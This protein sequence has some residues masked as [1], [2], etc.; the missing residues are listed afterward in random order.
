[1]KSNIVI[2]II[3][4]TGILGTIFK[5]FF[6]EQ[7]YEVLVSGRN[8]KLTSEELVKGA[9]VV[10]F[11]VPIDVT[12]E[13]IKSVIPYLR[14]EQ[15]LMDFTS[16]KLFSVKEMLKSRASVIGLH[17]MFGKVESVCGKTVVV[18]PA[19][20]GDWQEWIVDLLKKGEMKVKVTTADEHDKIMSVLQGLVH[21]NYI[22]LSYTL[23]EESE[24]LG[25][26]IN[27][28]LDYGGVI[29]DLRLGTMARTLGQDPEL[30][31]DLSMYNEEIKKRIKENLRQVEKLKKIIDRKDKVEFIKYFKEGVK[32]YKDFE[33]EALRDSAFLIK[34]LS[35]RKLEDK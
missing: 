19:R 34:Q 5:K 7:G 9:K 25:L 10:I 1:M 16:V 17:P 31:A 20:P 6:E 2:G 14:E 32:F 4:G 33:K 29:Y 12:A 13:A 8:T 23:K 27:D 24:K 22:S 3:G 18:V 28:L 15:L 26:D 35:K 30:Y 21:F 11:C